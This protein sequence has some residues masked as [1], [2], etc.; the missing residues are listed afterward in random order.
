MSNV[1]LASGQR[2]ELA[3][4]RQTWLEAIHRGNMDKRT[5]KPNA[6]YNAVLL[7][8]D[9]QGKLKLIPH[10]ML[11][12][13]PFYTGTAGMIGANNRAI[14]T[15]VESQCEYAGTMKTVI[16]KPGKEHVGLI[17]TMITANHG[18]TADGTPLLLLSNAKTGKPIRTDEEMGEADEILLKFNGKIRKY[19]I[20]SR[21][22]GLLEVVENEST[23]SYVSDTATIGL[24]RRGYYYIY[25]RHDV[26]LDGHPSGR[27]AVAREA[28]SGS[29]PATVG[30]A[31]AKLSAEIIDGGAIL[32]G[33]DEQIQT[34]L[35]VLRSQNLL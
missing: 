12:A 8:K 22:G 26:G 18:F 34:A 16:V 5:I 27:L 21:D 31:P 9:E 30:T 20:Q 10:E 15:S 6:F 28:A 25:L 1:F 35:R 29:A 23:Y 32:T 13:E 11:N 17:N 24:V 7:E 3:P 4:T 2:I 33:S 19:N 14:G